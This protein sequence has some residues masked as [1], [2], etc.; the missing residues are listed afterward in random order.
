MPLR[1][2]GRSEPE[3]GSP[4]GVLRAAREHE[5]YRFLLTLSRGSLDPQEAYQL[6]ER[7][8]RPLR[9]RYGI[10]VSG[11]DE[12]AWLDDPEG[13]YTWPLRLP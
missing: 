13:P 3:P 4:S 10:T 5:L 1:G 8:G 2:E 11:G 12:W 6:W 9:Q 7:E